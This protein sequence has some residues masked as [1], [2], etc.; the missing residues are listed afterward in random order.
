MLR[1]VSTNPVV[2]AELP[3]AQHAFEVFDSPR[4]LFTAGAVHRFLEAVRLK[5]GHGL[6]ELDPP[7]PPVGRQAEDS[8]PALAD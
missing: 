6:G 2:Y 8:E 7:G 3:G 1:A 4:T 5:A